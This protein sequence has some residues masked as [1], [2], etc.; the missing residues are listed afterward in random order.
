MINQATKSRIA[1]LGHRYALLA[2]DHRAALHQISLA[3]LP[4]TVHQSNAI[5]NSTLTL[6]DTE[7]ILAGGALP[8]GLNLREVYEARN[9]AAV[10]ASMSSLGGPPTQD[11]IVRWHGQLLAGIRDEVAGRFRRAD[12]WV[13]VG[14]H[15]GANP[16]FVP[17]LIKDALA[18]YTADESGY[19]VEQIARFHCE[20]EIIHPFVDGNGRIG[21][22]LMNAQLQALGW[23]PVIVRAKNRHRDYYPALERYA[24][25]DRHDAMTALIA[26]LL[27]ESLHKRIALLT[28]PRIITLASWARSAGIRG[29]VAANK[30]KRQTIPAFRMRDRWMIAAEHQAK[31]SEQSVR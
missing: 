12:E 27:Q 23:P 4:E 19:F 14:A 22:V 3:E 8:R 31:D 25:T 11:D 26:L 7:R 6:A 18:H 5:E 1:R 16:E 13:R 21:R 20:F 15:L 17:Q 10:T 2:A 29:N 9:L 30:A 24:S 28:A